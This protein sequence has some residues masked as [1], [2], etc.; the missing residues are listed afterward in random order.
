MLVSAVTDLILLITMLV[1]VLRLE[2]GSSMWRMLY[3]HVRGFTRRDV[4]SELIILCRAL[5]GFY[6]VPSD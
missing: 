5:S 3:R 2:S 6:Y 4:F 1:G